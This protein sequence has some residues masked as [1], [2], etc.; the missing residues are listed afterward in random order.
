MV[1]VT[2][3]NFRSGTCR[4]QQEGEISRSLEFFESRCGRFL[5]HLAR[6]RRWPMLWRCW[7]TWECNRGNWDSWGWNCGRLQKI[8]WFRVGR[9]LPGP[10]FQS[11]FFMKNTLTM[12]IH[13]DGSKGMWVFFGPFFIFSSFGHWDLPLVENHAKKNRRGNRLRFPWP[14]WFAVAKRLHICFVI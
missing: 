12:P 4:G 8:S 1:T 7:R 11:W 13:V 3:A 9:R 5:S 14:L 6:N 10:R 2:L